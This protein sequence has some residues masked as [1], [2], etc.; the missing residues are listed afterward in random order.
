M[1]N[2]LHSVANPWFT[3]ESIIP[4]YDLAELMGT[5][6]RA[7]YQ[8]KKGR[9]LFDLWLALTSHNVDSS[10]VVRCFTAYMSFNGTAVSRAQFEENM[11]RNMKDAHFVEDI[12]PLLRSGVEYS[13]DEA[14]EI[15][16]RSL[17]CLLPGEPWKGEPS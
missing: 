14:W 5:K 6:M 11:A 10:K 4:T 3:G 17:V 8:R 12:H 1:Q 15:V 16:H 13:V 9:D 2:R 7:L